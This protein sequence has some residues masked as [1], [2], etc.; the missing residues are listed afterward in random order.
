M[1]FRALLVCSSILV[2]LG[3][4]VATPHSAPPVDQSKA[5][6]PRFKVAVAAIVDPKAEQIHLGITVFGNSFDRGVDIPFDIDGEIDRALSQALVQSGRYDLIDMQVD[7]KDFADAASSFGWSA[8]TLAPPLAAKLVQAAQGRGI[9]HIIAV[10]EVRNPGPANA[11]DWG[12]FQHRNGCHS[13]Y[14]SY[15]VY[16]IDAKTGATE[17]S[18]S[19]LGY[20]R[21][22]DIAWD[23]AWSAI[24]QPKQAEI[25]GDLK[26]IV[27]QDVTGSLTD[28]GLLST[29]FS[30][31]G[32]PDQPCR[33]FMGG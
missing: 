31:F 9:D 12:L 10:V 11:E 16:V 20:R 23:A 33:P 17:K 25:L 21:V 18:I 14:I 7:P 15:S 4:C 5:A 26:S 22:K 6:A 2:S 19:Y 27:D 3:G 32:L 30:H 29:G 24:P 28:L 1:S 8:D 13:T